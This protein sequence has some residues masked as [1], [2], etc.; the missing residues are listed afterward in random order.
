M[1]RRFGVARLFLR[2]DDVKLDDDFVGDHR[3]VFPFARADIELRAFDRQA[4][5]RR[6]ACALA[7]TV[8]G[9]ATFC[10]LPLMVSLPLTLNWLPPAGAIAL[11]TNVAVGK[12]RGIE[13]VLAGACLL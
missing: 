2:R 3:R 5:H 13:P 6:F 4:S 8:T 12:W 1:L 10:D 9:T 7:A 11:D